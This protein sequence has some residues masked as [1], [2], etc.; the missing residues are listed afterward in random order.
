RVVL[1]PDRSRISAPMHMSE[2]EVRVFVVSKMG[3]IK[4]HRAE[5]AAQGTVTKPEFKDGA[6]HYVFGK[7]YLL[8]LIDASGPPAVVPCA[9]G[10]LEM[11][12]KNGTGKRQMENIMDGWYREILK[13]KVPEFV[14]K[15]EIKTG[16][17]VKEWGV[18][19]MKTRWG[20]CNTRAARIWLNMELAKRPVES[21]DYVVLHEIL[22]IAECNHGRRFKALMNRY[23]PEWK[24]IRKKLKYI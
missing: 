24:I 4:K 8:K 21:L 10:T 9:D 18:K 23:M 16:L 7:K 13:A 1:Y 20:T 3:W 17:K 14:A 15:W 6:V 22:H 19:K 2:E 12:V 11:R 5:F